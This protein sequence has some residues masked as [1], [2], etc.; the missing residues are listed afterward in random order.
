MSLLQHCITTSL[1]ILGEGEMSYG[2]QTKLNTVGNWKSGQGNQEGKSKQLRP[3]RIINHFLLGQA[4]LQLNQLPL[5]PKFNK[6]TDTVVKKEKKN[7]KCLPSHSWWILDSIPRSIP[8]QF[9]LYQHKRNLQATKLRS[10]VTITTK[11]VKCLR[12]GL[13][14]P[15]GHGF[16]SHNRK[17]WFWS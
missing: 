7:S 4:P 11:G 2:Q 16:N 14:G 9:W 1:Q 10:C 13:Q 15:L 6:K 17:W 5:L 3:K 12:H 8:I